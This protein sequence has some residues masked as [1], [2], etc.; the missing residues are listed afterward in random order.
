MLRNL[1]RRLLELLHRRRDHVP[2]LAMACIGPKALPAGEITPTHQRVVALAREVLR[3]EPPESPALRWANVTRELEDA[4]RALVEA[5]SR[6]VEE[7]HRLCQQGHLVVGT[8]CWTCDRGVSGCDRSCY[9][10]SD[11]LIRHGRTCERPISMPTPG[12][13][14]TI[15]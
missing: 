8:W 10:E 14:R 3:H 11:G 13:G 6:L 5:M 2:R 15:G 1:F 7:P 12:P 4:K 9:T